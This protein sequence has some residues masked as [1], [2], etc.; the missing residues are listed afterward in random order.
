MGI[1]VR[2]ALHDRRSIDL[3]AKQ[4]EQGTFADWT[5]K[6]LLFE[7]PK[8]STYT[9]GAS[10]LETELLQYITNGVNQQTYINTTENI[11]NN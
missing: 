6:K 8:P 9:I 4:L 3:F 11:I 5:I 2:T 1:A 10:Q 7:L